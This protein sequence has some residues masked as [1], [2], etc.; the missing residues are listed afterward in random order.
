VLV[1]LALGGCGVFGIGGGD[2][3]KPTP[4][5]PITATVAPKAA[6]T[7]SAGK[8]TPYQFTPATG[9]GRVYAASAEGIITV[10]DEASGSVASRI[11]TKK[12][13]SGGVALEGTT[14]IVGTIKGEVAAVDAGGK[15]LWS[16][17][18]S[19]EVIAP[20]SI[21]KGT[22]V[23]RTSDGRVFG[24]NLADGKRKWVYQRQSPALLL[25]TDAGVFAT[26]NNVVAG[27]PGG[28]LIALDL[29]DGKLTWEVSIT[30][31]RG[32]TELERIADVAGV[33]S[34][35][36]GRI[37]AAAFQGKAACFDIQ[38]RNLV[39]SR[40]VSSARAVA[41]DGKNAYVVDIN[42][43]V[44][45]FDKNS[46]ASLWKQDKLA[47]R[48]LST[49]MMVNGNVVVGDGFG[50]LHVLSAQDGALIGRLAIDSSAVNALV[51]ASRGLV[52]QTANGT[53]ALV[54]F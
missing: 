8:S 44:H 16:S 42:G 31:P 10:I 22:V 13:V 28:K 45:A 40:D 53:V 34:V 51:P 32:A 29:E 30:T 19:G 21:A 39:W 5:E 6:W 38:S 14:V 2:A 49:P 12:R 27:F 50:Y 41:L 47:Y 35:D 25:R 17:N 33:P 48:K 9:G 37:C 23:V 18:L 11:E 43:S 1:A 24:F 3:R 20:A 36:G 26:G 15:Q 7:V 52:V 4:L 54:S 46:G